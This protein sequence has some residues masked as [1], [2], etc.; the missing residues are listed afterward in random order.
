LWQC[1]IRCKNKVQDTWNAICQTLSV[2]TSSLRPTSHHRA[3][4]AALAV[5]LAAPLLT[6]PVDGTEAHQWQRSVI[7]VIVPAS[8]QE[9]GW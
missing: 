4:I 7:R 3:Q 8:K 9:R 1:N 5:S 2:T 6:Q